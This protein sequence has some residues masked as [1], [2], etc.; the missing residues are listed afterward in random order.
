MY[1]DFKPDFRLP[2]IKLYVR[3]RKCYRG[4]NKVLA[5]SRPVI[6]MSHTCRGAKIQVLYKPIIALVPPRSNY[7]LSMGPAATFSKKF[8][9]LKYGH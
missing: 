9:M 6:I 8:L 1:V 7:A 2:Y 3:T 5:L 4:S